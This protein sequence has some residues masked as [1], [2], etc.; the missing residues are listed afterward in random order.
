MDIDLDID[1]NE[2]TFAEPKRVHE[3][4]LRYAGQNTPT[5]TDYNHTVLRFAPRYGGEPVVADASFA[6]YSFVNGVDTFGE[7]LATK[8]HSKTHRVDFFGES[9][10]N[11]QLSKADVWEQSKTA[12]IIRTTNNVVA[13]ELGNVGGIEALLSMCNSCFQVTETR[14]VDAVKVE[15]EV[16]RRRLEHVQFGPDVTYLKDLDE[17]VQDC[18]GVGHQVC[19]LSYESSIEPLRYFHFPG[20]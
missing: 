12:S 1:I 17:L 18:D 6:Q 16:L 9:V 20:S 2:V 11:N 15:M 3:V 10:E 7:Y 5:R 4:Q 14:I 19:M 13:R 8:V